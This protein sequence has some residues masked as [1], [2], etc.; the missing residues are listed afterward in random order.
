[1]DAL[2][3]KVLIIA[4]VAMIAAITLHDLD[5]IRQARGWCYTITALLWVINGL[6]YIP[7]IF[8][9]VASVKRAR[10][11]PFATAFGALLIST[12]FAKVHLWKPFFQVWGVWN[13]SFLD[14]GADALSWGILTLLVTVA[15]FVAMAAAWADGRIH[16]LSGAGRVST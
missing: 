15:A 4:N 6:V 1:M 14:L 8:A 10:W 5:H 16:T 11:A 9:L 13:R 2:S 7:G 3:R 12:L